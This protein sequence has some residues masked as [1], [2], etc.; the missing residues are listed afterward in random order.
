[1]TA[2]PPPASCS[3][4]EPEPPRGL[5]VSILPLAR[6]HLDQVAAIEK[7]CFKNP[8]SRSLFMEELCMPMSMDQVALVDDQVAAFCCMWLVASMAKVQNLAVHPVFQRRGLGRYLLLHCLALA[9]EHG[10]VRAGLEVRTGN[11]AALSL[12]YSLEFCLEE[13]RPG[14]Y[15]PEGEDALLLRRGL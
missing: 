8:W 10:A 4:P 11:I 3:L 12:Y 13:R 5:R 6:K 14:Y 2:S 15:F 9:R 7:A 1:M